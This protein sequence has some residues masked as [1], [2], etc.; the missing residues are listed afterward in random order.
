MGDIFGQILRDLLSGKG[1]QAQPA[2]LTS[3]AGSA[4]FG[5]RLEVGPNV[6]Q[7]QLDSFQQVF[8]RFYG[9]PR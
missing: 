3:G 9:A 8:E 1:A 5:D 4:V 7:A 6:A 2:R